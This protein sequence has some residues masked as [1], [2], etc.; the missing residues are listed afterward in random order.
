MVKWSVPFP[1]ISDPKRKLYTLFG[2]KQV[3]ALGLISPSVAFKGFLAMTKGHAPGIAVG[4]VRQ[5]SG[6]FIINTDGRVVY[7]YFAKDPSD[8]P[9]TDTILS[10]LKAAA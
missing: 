4:D 2:L 9:D 1:L 7:S 8:H 5:L 10:E 6:V 3:S